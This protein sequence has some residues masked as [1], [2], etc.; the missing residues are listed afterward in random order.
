MSTA[1]ARTFSPGLQGDDWLGKFAAEYQN[2]LL[3]LFSSYV[4]IGEDF[5]P[6]MGFV[7][8]RGRR[9]LTHEFA[10]TPRMD[11][12]TRFGS[13]VRD[14][15]LSVASD[16]VFLSDWI[17]ETKVLQPQFVVEFQ[18]ASTFRVQASRNFERLDDEF[19]LPFDT[20][21]PSGDYDFNRYHLRYASNS[22]RLLSGSYQYSWG[23][24]F[25]GHRQ[26]HS[27]GLQVRP[28]YRFTITADYQRNY[29]QLPEARFHT[30]EAG[31]RF[32]YSFTSKM[33]LNAFFQHNNETDQ[34]TSNVRFRL[35][36]RPLSDIYVVYNEVRDRDHD[37]TDWTLSLKYTHLF[38]F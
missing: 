16:H 23:A 33:F 15:T 22:S 6:E 11:P 9:L 32:D 35:I 12:E 27:A 7:R 21:V 8:R 17:T 5:N 36:H 30:N 18:D 37:E 19:D 20:A 29:V 10:L 26:E 25:S 38:N 4:Q 14:M 13:W 2:N 1:F 24:F 3:R 34:V 31:L 28:S